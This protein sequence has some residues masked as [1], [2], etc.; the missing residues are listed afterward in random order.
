MVQ[1][2]GFRFTVNRLARRLGIEGWVRNLGDG[3]VELLCESEEG[4]L[5]DLLKQIRGGSLRNYIEETE[6]EWSEPT[7]EFNNFEIRFW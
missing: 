5:K 3:R 7:G 2:V 1:G 4:A 6:A